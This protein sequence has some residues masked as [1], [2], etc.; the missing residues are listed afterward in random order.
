MTVPDFPSSRHDRTFVGL[1]K[2]CE[3]ASTL[4]M[5]R[6]QD[7]KFLLVY[8]GEFPHLC[9]EPAADSLARRIRFPRRPTWVSEAAPWLEGRS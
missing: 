6:L 7:S 8:N 5:F 1:A 2:R 4:G 9:I 3:E